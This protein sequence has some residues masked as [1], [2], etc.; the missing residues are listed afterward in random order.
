MIYAH[1]FAWDAEDRPGLAATAEDLRLLRREG[2]P[3]RRARRRQSVGPGGPDNTH[4]TH[5]GAVHRKMI[6][7]ALKD[8]FGMP[9]PEEYSKRRP[10]EELLCW[11]EE[12]KKE[13]KPKKLHE[14]LG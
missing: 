9:I 8:W 10:A 4:C 14:V 12:A 5:I 13:L 6:Y 2:Q 1:E 11:T 7:P 3:P